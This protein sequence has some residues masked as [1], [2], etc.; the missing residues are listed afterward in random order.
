MAFNHQLVRVWYPSMPN[1][2]LVDEEMMF[3]FS[4]EIGD[5]S[6]ML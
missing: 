1:D 6:N 5:P 3:F 2:E 4:L